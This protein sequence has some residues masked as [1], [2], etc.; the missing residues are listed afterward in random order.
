MIL[1]NTSMPGEED[2]A[3]YQW[4]S[5]D[6]QLRGGVGDFTILYEDLSGG[7]TFT[8]SLTV[9]DS[10]GCGDV[11]EQVLTVDNSGPTINEPPVKLGPD[12]L[13]STDDQVDN[14]RWYKICNGDTTEIDDA[15]KG[16]R[17]FYCVPA[18]EAQ[19]SFYV[20]TSNGGSSCTTS[21]QSVKLDG[22]ESLP[23]SFLGLPLGLNV[24]PNPNAGKFQL[25]L[26]HQAQGAAELRILNLAGQQVF[27]QL[28]TKEQS[29]QS[30][31]VLTP[32]LSEGMYV[33]EVRMAGGLRFTEKMMV[34]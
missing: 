26:L 10:E 27:G 23:I 29:F 22:R 2:I 1:A 28:L 33:L 20:I 34:R 16:N 6:G 9:I 7:N 25:D 5:G 14:Y 13:V 12:I 18:E 32:S 4:N 15:A 11:F 8:A 30:W 21:S 24:Y 19:C 31:E 17:Q 3:S